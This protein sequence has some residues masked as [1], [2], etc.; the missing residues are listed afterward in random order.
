MALTLPTKVLNAKDSDSVC[1]FECYAFFLKTGTLYITN[2]DQDLT[3][4]DKTY[5]SVPIQRGKYT[6]NSESKV[7]DCTLKV[8]NVDDSFTAALY[9]GVD[10]RGQYVYV[11]KVLYPDI[12]ND[13][14]LVKPVVFG[15]LD[16]PILNQKEGTFEV[17]VKAQVPNTKNCRYFQLSCNAEFGDMDT[18]M[19]GK[20][21][22]SGVCQ[23]GT[24]SSSIVIEKS[25][26]DNHWAN[27]IITCGSESRMIESSQG[28]VINLHYPFLFP[29]A[30]GTTYSIECGCDKS[31]ANCKAAGQEKNFSGF[32]SIPYELTVRSN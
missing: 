26:Y 30:P 22:Q 4:G 29:V 10:F 6:S 18:C 23:N 32:P 21:K 12:I 14:T 5:I 8:S 3:F 1:F 31:F 15:Y 28:N 11:F 19:A 9:S 25:Y 27:G 24:T 13:R 7:E 17:T 16:S 20:D 2:A